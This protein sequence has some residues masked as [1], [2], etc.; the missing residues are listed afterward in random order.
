MKARTPHLKN[1]VCIP[2]NAIP[3]LGTV[4]LLFALALLQAQGYAQTAD[5]LYV[6]NRGA[7]NIM[8][9][10]SNGAGTQFNVSGPCDTPLR[11]A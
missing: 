11:Q 3:F 2:R 1:V 7:N 6:A 4:S 8:K 5:T 9:F 10:D